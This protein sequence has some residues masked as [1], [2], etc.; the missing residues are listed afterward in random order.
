M[1][2]YSQVVDPKLVID[3]L[4]SLGARLELPEGWSYEARV[5]AEDSKLMAEEESYVVTDDFKN[6]YQR[7]TSHD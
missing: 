1:Q 7:V 3:D 4:K 2:S 5:L 6:A